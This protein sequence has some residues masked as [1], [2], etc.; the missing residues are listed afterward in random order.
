S[1]RP[2]TAGSITAVPPAHLSTWAGSSRQLYTSS[3]GTSMTVRTSASPDAGTL[4]SKNGI[5][6]S[7]SQWAARL[8]SDTYQNQRSAVAS[9]V[10]V[11]GSPACVSVTT[12]PLSSP[13]SEP[14]S[15]I[16]TV[17]GSAWSKVQ[18]NRRASAWSADCSR[19]R[20]RSPCGV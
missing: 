12:V 6:G 19:W 13:A 10:P 11:A 18:V 15:D 3:T 9:A 16:S 20:G 17:D 8:A 2:P 5:V 14:A 7:A 4:K 1:Y